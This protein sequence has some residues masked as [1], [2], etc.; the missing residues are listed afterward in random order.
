AV[1]AR[2][3]RSP[4]KPKSQ[5]M[6]SLPLS[7]I[8]NFSGAEIVRGNA[9]TMISRVS[10]N[11]RTIKPGELFVALQGEHFDA[12]NFLQDVAKA[13]AAGAIVSQ[14]PPPDLPENFAILPATDTLVAYQN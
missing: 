6:N 10:T 9:E 1:H 7:Q 14:N 2:S 4:P 11:S 12:H 8:A 3:V 13:G 5:G